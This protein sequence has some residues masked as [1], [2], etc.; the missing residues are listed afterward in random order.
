MILSTG[1]QNISFNEGSNTNI[2]M[3]ISEKD[4][5][6]FLNETPFNFI[7][8]SFEITPDE[9]NPNILSDI[10]SGGSGSSLSEINF[11][12][13]DL[14]AYGQESF[15]ITLDDGLSGPVNQSFLISVINVNDIPNNY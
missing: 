3:F 13:E 9:S 5:D 15:T 4:S 7:D 6:S 14:D 10:T 2:T 12:T 11:S 1:Y 8:M